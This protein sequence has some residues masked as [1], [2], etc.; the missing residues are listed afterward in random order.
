[1]RLYRVTATAVIVFCLAATLLAQNNSTKQIKVVGVSN[2]SLQPGSATTEVGTETRTAPEVDV[3]FTKPQIS[4]TISPARVPSAHVPTPAGSAFA[5]TAGDTF[6]GFNAISHR[7]QRLADN[8]NQF[9]VEPPDQG[10]AV[11]NGFVVEAVNDAVRVFN[12]SGVPQTGTV[13]LNTFLKLPSQIVRGN[14]TVFGP[15]PT[16]PKVYFDSST[17]RFFLTSLVLSVNS[18]TGALITPVNIFIAVSQTSDP[19]SNWTILTLDVTND[20]GPF[21]ACPCFGDQPL[22]GADANGFYVSTNAFSLSTFRFSGSNIYAMSK[23][24]LESASAGAIS[25]VRFN[26]PPEAGMP[27]SFSIQP[28]TVPPGGTFAT[29]TEFFLSALDFTNTV[30]NRLVVWA[31]T[32]T[33]TLNSATP[34]LSLVNA[35]VNTQSY[36]APPD[37]QQKAGPF[38]L[39]TA[40]KNHLELVASNDDRMQQV[41]FADGKLWTALNSSAKTQNGPV[42]TVA[43]WFILSPTSGNGAVSATVV[44]Q[45]YIGINDPS[46]QSVLFPSVGVNSNGKGVV[47]FSVVGTNFF[48][49]AGYAPIDVNGT[50][51]IRVSGPGA[52]PEDGFSGYPQFPPGFRTARWGDYS[53]AVSDESGAIWMGNEYIPNAPRTVNANWGTFIGRFTP[54]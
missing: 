25:A 16:D 34:Q 46:Q 18:S 28:A 50:G 29:N 1:M 39:G 15:E 45:G 40:L 11:G 37:A 10:L 38:P 49:S 43:A 51:A 2:M 32:G 23:T 17:G 52:L 53:A 7:D 47:A 30:D 22:I 36:G 27:F 9:S 4:G 54:K 6:F 21:A 33:D 3:R 31:L 35:V 19:T 8:G 13:A 12:T 24:A 44:N 14:P 5:S 20:G 42:R 48:P 41:V 26:N